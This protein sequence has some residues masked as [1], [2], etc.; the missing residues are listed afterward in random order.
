MVEQE[1]SE[2]IEKCLGELSAAQNG[3]ID[4]LKAEKVAALFLIAQ[5]RMSDLLADF[6]LRANHSKNMI[7]AVEAEVYSEIKNSAASGSKIT[8]S[9]LS[10]LIAKD[11][12]VKEAKKETAKHWSALKKYNYLSNTIRDGHHYFK[13]LA[14]AQTWT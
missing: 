4:Q 6:E 11:E 3:D 2:L 12:R 1:V 9:A 7:E 14:K 8:E 13:G 5:I 10:H